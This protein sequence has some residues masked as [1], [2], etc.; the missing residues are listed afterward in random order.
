MRRVGID[1]GTTN[2]IAC[3]VNEAGE[4]E[5][6]QFDK[7]RIGNRYLLPSCIAYD[8]STGSFTVGSPALKIGESFPT[9]FLS[10]LKYHIGDDNE[11]FIGGQRITARDAAFY[12][13]KEVHDQLRKKFPDETD[14]RAFVTVPAR[15][16]TQPPR[17]AT[18]E[19]AERAGFSIDPDHALTDEPIAAAIAYSSMMKNNETALVVDIGGGTF[20]L[21][22]LRAD[23]NGDH[24]ISRL[25][26]VGW[27][28]DPHLGGNDVDELIL[29]IL[30]KK[31]KEDR[32]TDLT[33][34][35]ADMRYSESESRAAIKLRDE[36]RGIK[37]ALYSGAD[38]YCYI[39][40][41]LSGYDFECVITREEYI[42]EMMNTHTGGK[43]PIAVRMQ[44][45]INDTFTRHGQQI[46]SIA[47][48]VVAGGMSQEICLL[49]YLRSTFGADR[50]IVPEDAIYLIAK[51]AAIANSDT[52]IRV[53]NIAYRSIGVL[54]NNGADVDTIIQE[55]SFIN[56]NFSYTQTY[57]IGK[58]EHDLLIVTIVEYSGGFR[59]DNYSVIREFEVPM[60]GLY[61]KRASITLNFTFSSDKILTVTDPEQRRFSAR[62]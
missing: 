1:L 17:V 13:L 6:L 3:F 30:C 38:G 5:L 24:G 35:P 7:G 45:A 42:N 15:F 34:S 62:L 56:E 10:D 19:A 32:Q 4:A 12:I 27:G 20:D 55:G 47:V 53:D 36:I 2:T 21:S 61:R 26:P 11:Y 46:S 28:G 57:T 51:G 39:Q 37:E 40:D 48:V 41:L 16:D 43:E 8:D 9:S 52:D 44:Q 29:S 22:L 25:V 31:V 60:T 59:S 58:G 14:F 49:E 33:H 18:R 23:G 50:V 54:I